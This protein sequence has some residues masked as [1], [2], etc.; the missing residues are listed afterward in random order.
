MKSP[1]SAHPEESRQHV[2]LDAGL[3]VIARHAKA[4][5][6]DAVVLFLDEII[7]WLAHR[8]S[9]VTWFHNEVQKLVKLV[10]AQDSYREVPIVSFLAR[11]R[12]LAE[13]VGKDYAGVENALL[14]EPAQ[15]VRAALRDD[16]PR[17]PEPPG[18]RRAP[19][20]PP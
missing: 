10:E 9:D 3:A 14:Q 1:F 7:L 18:D 20:A 12:D 11:Q 16:H 6:Y 19:R 13:M 4:L 15:V 17:G 2:D 5:G 8:A